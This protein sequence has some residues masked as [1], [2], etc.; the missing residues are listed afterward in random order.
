VAYYIHKQWMF[1]TP[2]FIY[3]GDKTRLNNGITSSGVW[4]S[5]EGWSFGG[6]ISNV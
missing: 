1:V 3:V 5:W 6:K 4:G 2:S